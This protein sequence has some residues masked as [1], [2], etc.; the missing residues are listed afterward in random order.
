MSNGPRNNLVKRAVTGLWAVVG[1]LMAAPAAADITVHVVDDAGSPIP[2]GFR[3]QLEEDNTY[4]IKKTA[5]NGPWAGPAAPGAPSLPGT[6]SPTADWVPGGANPTH[7]LSVNI[8]RSHAPTVCTGDTVTPLD[9]I[10]SS[11]QPFQGHQPC[12]SI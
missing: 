11:T 9:P 12:R 2:N 10:G 4:G 7:T 5:R 8:H 3:W 6:P 1:L